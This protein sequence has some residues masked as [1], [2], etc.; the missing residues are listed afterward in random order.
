MQRQ[1]CQG[2]EYQLCNGNCLL[3]LR[4]CDFLIYRDFRIDYNLDLIYLLQNC[5][6]GVT[7]VVCHFSGTNVIL[8]M[9]NW[10]GFP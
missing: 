10:L 4:T 6:E 3:G 9:R 1:R 7:L 5:S 8:K 2:R